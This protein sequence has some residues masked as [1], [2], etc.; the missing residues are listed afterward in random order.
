MTKVFQESAL[1]WYLRK[2][3]KE[4]FKVSASLTYIIFSIIPKYTLHFFF[5][6]FLPFF[7]SLRFVIMKFMQ[8]L[9]LVAVTGYSVGAFLK[10]IYF[11]NLADLVATTN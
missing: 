3:K 2:Y 6:F 10:C 5:L 7:I 11:A 9:S 4:V 1:L 8:K